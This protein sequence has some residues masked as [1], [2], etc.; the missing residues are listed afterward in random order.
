MRI[1]TGVICDYAEVREGLLTI[2]SAGLTRLWRPQLPAQMGVFL[3][4]QIELD[5]SE[6]HLPHEFG[7]V[8]R[9]PTGN[10]VGKAAGG[11]Q[12][13]E[14]LPAEPN[15]TATASLPLDLRP[16][17]LA[18]YGWHEFV[19]S[20]DSEEACRMRVLVARPPAPPMTPG[21]RIAPQSTIKH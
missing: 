19:I 4:L 14:G 13:A 2:V 20:I 6:R 5:P 7:V 21:I 16:I 3:A 15:E 1:A 18:E 9:G 11:F 17:P 12:I 8:I 10:E